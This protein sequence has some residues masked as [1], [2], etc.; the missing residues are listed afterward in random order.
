MDEQVES[1]LQTL[2]CQ[3]MLTF[4]RLWV[5]QITFG[6]L[7]VTITGNYKKTPLVGKDFREILLHTRLPA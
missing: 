3:L 1:S 4:K 2:F 6:Y 5:K 7:K